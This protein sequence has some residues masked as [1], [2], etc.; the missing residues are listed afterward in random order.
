MKH[1]GFKRG[2]VVC[3]ICNTTP[4]VVVIVMAVASLGG[5]LTLMDPN[6]SAS[7]YPQV[8]K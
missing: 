5:S 1:A 4:E 8:L 6:S 3:A 2:S 7:I